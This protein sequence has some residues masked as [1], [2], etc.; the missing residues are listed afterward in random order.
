MSESEGAKKPKKKKK[1]G[2]G[3]KVRTGRITTKGRR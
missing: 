3:I 1:I 2:G